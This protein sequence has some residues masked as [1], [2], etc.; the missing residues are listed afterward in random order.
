[1]S[2]YV[3]QTYSV[4][5]VSD[6]ILLSGYSSAGFLAYLSSNV[7]GSHYTPIPFDTEEYDYGNNYNPSTGIYTVPLDGLYLIHARVYGADN[8]AAHIIKVDTDGVT[9]S[10]AYDPDYIYQQATT[11]IVLHLLAGQEVTVDPAF[12]GTVGGDPGYM[13]TSFG[14]S[15]LYPTLPQ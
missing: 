11:S 14:A 8:W 4:A 13:R 6:D 9:Y 5:R 1:M 3:S 12:S 7:E 2:E 10:L 15:L